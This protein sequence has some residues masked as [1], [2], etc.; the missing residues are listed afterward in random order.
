MS[1]PQ[2]S[3]LRCNACSSQT[4]IEENTTNHFFVLYLVLSPQVAFLVKKAITEML[5]E[6]ERSWQHKKI[7]PRKWEVRTGNTQY[8]QR[9]SNLAF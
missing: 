7:L 5:G 8:T 6:K 3:L 4:S 2:S 9:L 1:P